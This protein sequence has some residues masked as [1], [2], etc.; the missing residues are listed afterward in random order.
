[1]GQVVGE[2][3]LWTREGEGREMGGREIGTEEEREGRWEWGG[4]RDMRRGRGVKR[5]RGDKERTW[6]VRSCEYSIGYM[7]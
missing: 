2:E 1:M 4:G 3:D 5:D 6:N 7:K